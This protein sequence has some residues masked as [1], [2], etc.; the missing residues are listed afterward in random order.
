MANIA[1]II[2]FIFMIIAVLLLMKRLQ[3]FRIYGSIFLVYAGISFI[4]GVIIVCL[5][6]IF[7]DTA[8]SAA[9]QE[10]IADKLGR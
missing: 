9:A 7:D 2:G 4:F 1:K 3:D 10:R 5:G 8:R 6:I